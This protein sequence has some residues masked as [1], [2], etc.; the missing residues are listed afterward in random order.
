MFDN[1]IGQRETTTTLASQIA[2]GDLP[3]AALFHGPAYSAKLSTALEVARA[4][5]CLRGSAE[6]SCPCASCERHRLLT[7]PDLLLLGQRY[8]DVEMAASAEVLRRTR[9]RAARFLFVRA[10]RKLLRRFDPALWD[11][12]S[13][14]GR[15]VLTQVATVEDLLEELPGE[16]AAVELLEKSALAVVEAATR[17]L[18][19]L[20]TTSIPIQQIRRLAQWAHLAPGLS[21]KVAVIEGADAINESARNALLKLLEEPP[22]GVTLILTTTRR[23]AIM[24]TIVSRLRP[25]PFGER[26]L[27]EQAEVLRRIFR[28]EPGEYP[29]L[30]DYFLAWRALNPAVL[31]SLAAR[32]VALLAGGDHGDEGL[33]ELLGELG[34]GG[35]TAEAFCVFCEELLGELQRRLADPQP[36]LLVLERWN[37]L[38]REAA[39]Y[40]RQYNPGASLQ[41]ESLYYRMRAVA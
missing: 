40:A 38:V 6:W 10:V 31:R 23:S 36:G 39:D 5:C 11:A 29:R 8:F 19:N 13:G 30:R 27:D 25:Y 17:L 41:L 3:R 33:Q 12:D 7:H 4:L 18:D 16:N 24:P 14:E 37:A 35:G 22:E 1:I 32:F 28:E 34:K 20:R 15:R 2:A 26:T 9:A 21:R